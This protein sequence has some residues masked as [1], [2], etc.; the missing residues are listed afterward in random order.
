MYYVDCIDVKVWTCSVG[1]FDDWKDE[2]RSVPHRAYA[3]G[4]EF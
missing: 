4:I 2:F 1:Q 3:D